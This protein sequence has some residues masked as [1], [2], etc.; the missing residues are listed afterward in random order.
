MNS[1]R[2]LRLPRLLLL[3]V[4]VAG[5]ACA[6]DP[7]RELELRRSAYSA[8]LSGFVL[9]DE[10]GRERPEVVLDVVIEGQS[11][12]PLAGI[13]VDVSMVDAAEREKAHR[14][15][16]V[17]LEGAGPGGAQVALTFDDL[18]YAPG[19]GFWVEVR[20]PVPEAERGEYRELGAVR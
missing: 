16:W 19:D 6:G 12:P 4:V 15:S 2:S 9:R 20:V 10:P 18:D 3:G 14:R 1:T 7:V 8:T 5:S 11:R 13:T 17:D